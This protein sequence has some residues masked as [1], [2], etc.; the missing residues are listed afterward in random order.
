M[1]NFES[2]T[3]FLQYL[4]NFH[5][6]FIFHLTQTVNVKRN[7]LDKLAYIGKKYAISMKFVGF[8]IGLSIGL[9]GVSSGVVF[10]TGVVRIYVF[11]TL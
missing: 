11:S 10:V 1:R 7:Y 6:S 5:M 4:H 8:S 2:P 9:G 3:R